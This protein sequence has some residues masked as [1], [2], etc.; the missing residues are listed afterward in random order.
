MHC[1]IKPIAMFSD[2]S[3]VRTEHIHLIHYSQK[4]LFERNQN[5]NFNRFHIENVCLY[6]YQAYTWSRVNIL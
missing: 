1:Q 6:P 3:L 4:G 2:Q 5:L